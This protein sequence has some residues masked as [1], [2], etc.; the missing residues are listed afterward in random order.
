METVATGGANFLPRLEPS[1]S[2]RNCS[3]PAVTVHPPLPPPGLALA[4]ADDKTPTY[5][6]KLAQDFPP[7][8][9]K[10]RRLSQLT[11][12]ALSSMFGGSDDFGQMSAAT[13]KKLL[14]VKEPA[15]AVESQPEARKLLNHA[16][17]TAVPEFRH[18]KLLAAGE[19]PCHGA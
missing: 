14:Q 13:G 11:G 6:R 18:K 17:D 15:A 19:Q 10:G 1:F 9:D 3:R 7:W 8:P 2:P 5:I 4:D 12:V 16:G